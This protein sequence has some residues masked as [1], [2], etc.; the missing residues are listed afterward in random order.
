MSDYEK[1]DCV[2]CKHERPRSDSTSAHSD[3]DFHYLSMYSTVTSVSLG[4][5]LKMPI[6][7][8]GFLDHCRNGLF[9]MLMFI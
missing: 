5:Q 1:G 8:P 9:Q 7:L 4:T 6:C 2:L 3:H